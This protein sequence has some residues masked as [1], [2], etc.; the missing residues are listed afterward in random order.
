MKKLTPR[1]VAHV[2]GAFDKAAKD[3]EPKPPADRLTMAEAALLKA[4]LAL[5][6]DERQARLGLGRLG[7]TRLPSRNTLARLAAGKKGLIYNVAAVRTWLAKV[8]P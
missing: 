6:P 1:D 8:Q 5:P 3:A 4:I 2:V 7:S